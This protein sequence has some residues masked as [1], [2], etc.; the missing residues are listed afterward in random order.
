MGPL[1]VGLDC[2]NMHKFLYIW[3]IN[4]IWIYIWI[5]QTQFSHCHIYLSNPINCQSYFQWRQFWGAHQFREGY[6]R[7][8]AWIPVMTPLSENFGCIRKAWLTI[9]FNHVLF[10]GSRISDYCSKS[11]HTCLTMEGSLSYINN[12][13]SL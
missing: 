2:P 4:M 13:S 11:R 7:K 6:L 3:N 12:F 1:L 5:G 8:K 10:K 9:C